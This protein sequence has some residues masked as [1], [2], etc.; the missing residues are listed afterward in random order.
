MFERTIHFALIVAVAAFAPRAVA[1]AEETL[2]GVS[3]SKPIVQPMPEPT[4]EAQANDDGSITVGNTRVK[5]SG[6]VTVDIGVGNT[7]KPR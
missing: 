6:S 3:P 4:E 7:P 1:C 2:P 5:I